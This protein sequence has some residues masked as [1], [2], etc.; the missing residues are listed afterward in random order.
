MWRGRLGV[1]NSGREVCWTCW[2][3]FT[4]RAVDGG[5]SGSRDVHRTFLEADG[6]KIKRRLFHQQHGQ[7]YPMVNVIFRVTSSV[8]T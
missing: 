1:R 8:T 7:N 5:G 4:A 3:W 6:A 2:S